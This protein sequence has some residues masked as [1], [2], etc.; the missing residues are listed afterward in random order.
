MTDD[1][2]EA[3][4]ERAAIIQFAAGER[5]AARKPGGWLASRHRNRLL[6]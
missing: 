4:E 1:E 5:L 2:Y 3:L 6:R